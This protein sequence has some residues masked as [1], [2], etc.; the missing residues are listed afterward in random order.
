MH[1]LALLIVVMG[2]LFGCNR[3]E[4]HVTRK[5]HERLV[6]HGQTA[7]S[8]P[9]EMEG[10]LGRSNVLHEVAN[11]RKNHTAD[12]SSKAIVHERYKL[13]LYVP[14]KVDLV[15]GR[16]TGTDGPALILLNQVS[17]V[18]IYPSGGASAKFDTEWRLSGEQWSALVESKGDWASVGIPVR[19][20]APIRHISEYRRA[21]FQE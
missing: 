19:S 7:L 4:P 2:L 1:R 13:E 10:L 16:I 6:K 20:N 5:I 8:Y 11:Y 9:Q 17:K 3:R 12:W 15:T 21:M 14:V 18:E